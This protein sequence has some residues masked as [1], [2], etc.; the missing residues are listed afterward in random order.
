MRTERAR[1]ENQLHRMRHSQLYRWWH[2]MP[3]GLARIQA[4]H[5]FGEWTGARTR[6]TAATRAPCL[7]FGSGSAEEAYERYTDFLELVFHPGAPGQQPRPIS[8]PLAPE[9]AIEEAAETAD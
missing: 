2:Q 1:R 6:I 8:A 9:P 7:R 3:D 4:M 5:W